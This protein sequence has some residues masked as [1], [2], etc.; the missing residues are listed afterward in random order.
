MKLIDLDFSVYGTISGRDA[1][2]I[3]EISSKNPRKVEIIVSVCTRSIA[4]KAELTEQFVQFKI[5][6][7]GV[8]LYK[9]FDEN[10]RGLLGEEEF[11]MYSESDAESA[12]MEIQGSE[13]VEKNKGIYQSGSLRHL[14]LD[15]YDFKVETLCESFT[16][17]EL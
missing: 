6:F 15:T 1:V 7:D 13:L 14:I 4:N 9:I 16:I 8:I 2:N 10:I 17:K 11:D 3:L 5:M 12:L